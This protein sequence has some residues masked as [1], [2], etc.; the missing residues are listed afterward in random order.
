LIIFNNN[1][2]VGKIYDYVAK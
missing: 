1:N 2:S